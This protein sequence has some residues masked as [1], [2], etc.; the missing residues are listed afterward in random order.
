[1]L[2]IGKET[3]IADARFSSAFKHP[4]DWRLRIRPT[5][6]R[7]NG[8]YLCQI[9]THPPTILVSHMQVIGKKLTIFYIGGWYGEISVFK[10]IG[11]F[12]PN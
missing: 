3:F 7:D 10:R 12:N 1:M 5:N 4:Y 8:T 2:T 6:S 11:V 9:S